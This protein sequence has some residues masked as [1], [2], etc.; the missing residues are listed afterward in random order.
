MV[1][2]NFLTLGIIVIGVAESLIAWPCKPICVLHNAL[3]LI[4]PNFD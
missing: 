1:N 2:V 4:L 3:I